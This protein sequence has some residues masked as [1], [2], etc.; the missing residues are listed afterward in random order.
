MIENNF[1]SEL[2]DSA[3]IYQYISQFVNL[4]NA[5]G[6]KY[7]GC[8]PFHKEKTASFFVD[9]ASGFYHCF[10]CSASGDIISFAKGYNNVSFDEAVRDVAGYFN[11]AVPESRKE[12]IAEQ[13]QRMVAYDIFEDAVKFFKSS[14]EQKSKKYLYDRNLNNAIIG[15]FDIGFNC[16]GGKLTKF[17]L[18]RG[19]KKEDLV[20]YSLAREFKGNLLDFFYNRIIVPIQDFS[21]RYVAF[22]ARSIDGS[23]PKYINSAGSDIFNKSKVIFN[24]HRAQQWIKKTRKNFILVEGY[25]DVIKMAQHGFYGAIATMGTAAT[26]FHIKKI[27]ANDASPVVCFNSDEAGQKAMFKLAQILITNL[28]NADRNFRFTILKKYND[29][30]DMLDDL[31]ESGMCKAAIDGL[32][33][34]SLYLE[35]FVWQYLLKIHDTSRPGSLSIF[36]KDCYSFANLAQDPVIK[37]SYKS[38]FKKKIKDFLADDDKNAGNKKSIHEGVSFDKVQDKIAVLLFFLIH[39]DES[40]ADASIAKITQILDEATALEICDFSNEINRGTE[41]IG[42]NILRIKGDFGQSTY[43]RVC[44]IAENYRDVINSDLFPCEKCL[45][46]CYLEIKLT[47]INQEKQG[48]DE[49]QLNELLA[50]ETALKQS[51][52]SLQYEINMIFD[53]ININLS[54]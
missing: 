44:K 36:I 38:F 49:S 48:S 21:G 7:K 39:S 22:G 6:S 17:L 13:K 54:I 14:L 53:E 9:D 23:M 43:D 11:I 3:S 5:G 52:V 19:Y 35:D 15:F 4:K 31:N 25:M 37:V 34:K 26:E 12:D 28:E 33:E 50:L 51:I 20:R 16:S 30:D 18:S 46:M 42:E 32:F 2:K 45:E 29:I 47:I 41:F 1:I 8:C 24:F 10:G 27:I 40:I